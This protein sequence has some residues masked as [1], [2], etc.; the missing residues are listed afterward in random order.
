MN[1]HELADAYLANPTPLGNFLFL[2][3][4]RSDDA[5]HD[6]VGELRRRLFAGLAP[7]PAAT[8]FAE[9]SVAMGDPLEVVHEGGLLSDVLIGAIV[10]LN[11]SPPDGND[12]ATLVELARSTRRAGGDASMRGAH[13]LKLVHDAAP[14]P[15]V[16]P[17]ALELANSAAIELESIGAPA[18]LIF[19]ARGVASAVEFSLWGATADRSWLDDSIAH[20]RAAIA[21]L[22][23]PSHLAAVGLADLANRLL[24]RFEMFNE[25]ADVEEAVDLN[26]RA[27]A[28]IAA[29]APERLAILSNLAGAL[30]QRF[31]ALRRRS[32]LDRAIELVVDVERP[33]LAGQR[34]LPAIM[35]TLAVM[36]VHRFELGGRQDDIVQ[37]VALAT[38]AVDLTPPRTPDSGIYNATLADARAAQIGIGGERASRDAAVEAARASLH[39][40]RKEDG[41]LPSRLGNLAVH[42]LARY[43]LD[44][45]VYEA[46]LDEAVSLVEWASELVAPGSASRW[47]I[48]S[49]LAGALSRRSDRPGFEADL[50]RS[51]GLFEHAVAQADSGGR[52]RPGTL[53]N[54]AIRLGKRY[55]R[56]GNEVDLVAVVDLMLEWSDLCEAGHG[57]R[58]EVT[59]AGWFWVRELAVLADAG[60]P[61]LWAPAARVG[62]VT[63]ACAERLAALPGDATEEARRIQAIEIRAAID[64]MAPLTAV[65][66]LR[67]G[68]SGSEV[69][70]VLES[71]LTTMAVERSGRLRVRRAGPEVAALADRLDGVADSLRIATARDEDIEALT[72]EY[73]GLRA[74]IEAQVGP[75]TPHR[76][77]ADLTEVARREDVTLAW[78]AATHYGAL[79]GR[80]GPDGAATAKIVPALTWDVAV[81]WH[82]RLHPMNRPPGGRLL[83][84]PEGEDR[85]TADAIASVLDELGAALG[86]TWRL[87]DRCWLVPAGLLAA[88]PWHVRWPGVR[89]H[90]SAALHVRAHAASGRP[91]PRTAAII[92][93]PDGSLPHAGEEGFE[94][95]ARLTGAPVPF[96]TQMRIGTEATLAAVLRF[97]S[98]G[99]L[100]VAAHGST[101]PAL[102]LAADDRLRPE[103]L[104]DQPD[105]FGSLRLLFPNCCLSGALP[106]THLDEAAGF[107]TAASVAGAAATLA[108]LWPV[109]DATAAS[110]AAHFYV[111]FARDGDPRAALQHAREATVP[112]DPEDTSVLAYQLYGH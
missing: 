97:G 74:A 109:D 7:D 58:H 10:L 63:L 75:L 65:A 98:P 73:A 54:L 27:F 69:L 11:T 59:A 71:G 22:E 47:A 8:S 56:D 24:V 4:L 1:A 15:E 92:A 23:A 52:H 50:D 14:R 66:H 25:S 103:H 53:N 105:T 95:Q 3:R 99:V 12:L 62:R 90:T 46:D 20:L 106:P 108:A 17:E 35:N 42:L 31:G 77:V 64:G 38:R 6:L 88:L 91:A 48:E 45:I 30:G 107:A 26:E 85:P 83:R 43:D 82:M 100:H 81:D 37:A 70:G 87:D 101:A 102:K 68:G 89:L 67:A 111:S 104:S 33:E 93:D 78:I 29:E 21:L 9:L 57:G 79:V 16:L 39:A 76:T 13:L 72:G 84:G 110:F 5:R 60:Q 36:L 19:G 55:R 40:A 61:Q 34:E 18:R 94:V 41:T 44:E 112:F 86:D 28:A 51:I 49:T 96:A 32:D 2:V 80:L